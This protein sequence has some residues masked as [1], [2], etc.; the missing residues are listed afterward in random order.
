M[1]RRQFPILENIKSGRSS[2][3]QDNKKIRKA[4]NRKKDKILKPLKKLKTRPPRR[5]PR[6]KYTSKGKRRQSIRSKGTYISRNKIAIVTKTKVEGRFIV[7]GCSSI[8]FCEKKGDLIS[9][10]KHF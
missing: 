5:I 9:S 3:S 1:K 8:R 2:K 6:Q 7:D 10:Q 4:Q